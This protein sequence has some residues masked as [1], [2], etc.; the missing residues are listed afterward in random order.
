LVTVEKVNDSDYLISLSPNSSLVGIYRIIFL[1]S[2]TLVCGGIGVIFYFLGAALILP[3]AGLELSILFVAFYLSFK[4][5]SK[6]EKI[7]ISQDIVKVERGINKAEYSWKEFR[8]FTY[9][10]IKKEKDKTIRLSFRSKG[11]DIFIG[12]FLNEDD[13]K[14]LKDEIT[15]IIESLNLKIY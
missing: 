8:T 7:Y 9:F 11:E 13:K 12:E 1:A 15:S 10:K 4:W 3:F 6:K 14:I 5:S 2:I